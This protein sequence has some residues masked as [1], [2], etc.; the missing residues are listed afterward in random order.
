ME[1]LEHLQRRDA[2]PGVYLIRRNWKQTC[3]LL[4]RQRFAFLILQAEV[5]GA[6]A[7]ELDQLPI[8]ILVLH[9]AQAQA[10]VLFQKPIRRSME[11]MHR[12]VL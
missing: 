9:Q 6:E 8:Q 11:T 5:E 2:F 1:A 7:E 10:Q 12:P 3:A 4:L